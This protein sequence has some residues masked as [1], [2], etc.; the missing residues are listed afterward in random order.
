MSGSSCSQRNACFVVGSDALIR[1]IEPVREAQLS[2]FLDPE[3]NR[4]EDIVAGRRDGERVVG[5][6]ARAT[7]SPRRRSVAVRRLMMEQHPFRS[8]RLTR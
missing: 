2:D 6:L 7:R 4:V 8:L 5:S 3:A 1:S